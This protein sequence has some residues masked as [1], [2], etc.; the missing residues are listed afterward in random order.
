MTARHHFSRWIG[1][2]AVITSMVHGVYAADVVNSANPAPGPGPNTDQI[3][4]GEYLAKAADCIACHTVDPAKPFAGGYPLATPFGTIYGPN[5]T[6]DKETGIGNWSDEDFV[7]ALHEGIDDE[8]KHL[9]PAF[10]Y[11]SFTKLSRDD[12]LAIKAYLFSLPPIQQKTPENKLPFPLNQRWVLAG[13]NLFN[14]KPGELKPDTAKSPEWNRGMY[15]VEGLAHCQECHTPRN[16]TMGVD[17]K[18]AFGGAQLGGWTAFNITP[19]PVSGVGGWKD[20]EL[21]QYLKT[22]LVPGK[23]SAA[24]GMAEAVEHSL[25]YLNDDDLKAIVT[26][27]R[28]VPAIND[29]ADKK[30]RYAW[31]QPS[32]D[33]ADLRCIAAVSVSNNASGGAELFSGNCASCHSA[34]GSGVVGGYYPSLF[35]NSVVGARDPGNLLMVILNGVQR[36]GK[37]G[38]A[39]MPG[40]ADHLNDAQIATLA[41]YILK[42][43]GHADAP[44]I[45]PELVKTQ[46][47]GG[48][49]S[50]LLTLLPVG[51]AV[52]AL[53]VV[54]I[55][56]LL[57]GR[58]RRKPSP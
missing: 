32:D 41:N 53:I 49:V 9:Y 4:R 14:F 46:R 39:F 55:L 38:E 40:F 50:P 1:A 21:I 52:A 43:Y 35:S 22:G 48:P 25:Q 57:F 10:P 5:I 2:M 31:G 33:D 42:Q 19:D 12:V 18:R 13:W 29:A 45:T 30:P 56:F 34:S 3:K 37:D 15:L 6:P 16:V 58:R 51:L 36:H 17:G 28:S 20:E 47:Q 54:F 7:R 44:T 11:A 26:Y 27:L 8:G 24:G 23:A